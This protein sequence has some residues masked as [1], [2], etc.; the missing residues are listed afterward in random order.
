MTLSDSDI[1]DELD[2]WGHFAGALRAEDKAL[3][4]EMLR[5]CYEYF[6]AIQARE[7]PFP[8]EG[9]FMSILLMQHKTI[10]WLAGEVEK[11]KEK[12]GAGLDT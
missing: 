8:S 3:F 11:L 10:V 6:P 4:K 2:S 5:L 12:K 7:S 9:L 1:I